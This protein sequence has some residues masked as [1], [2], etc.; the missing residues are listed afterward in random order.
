MAWSQVFPLGHMSG[1]RRAILNGLPRLLC[2]SKQMMLISIWNHEH[3]YVYQSGLGRFNS[4]SVTDTLVL[5]EP[6]LFQGGTFAG[7]CVIV[8]LMY[9]SYHELSVHGALF[10]NVMAKHCLSYNQQFTLILCS[11]SLSTR[12]VSNFL[13][14]TLT[15]VRRLH[16]P[17]HLADGQALHRRLL[18]LGAPGVRRE[19]RLSL[20][21]LTPCRPR[22]IIRRRASCFST[23]WFHNAIEFKNSNGAALRQVRHANGQLW[24][25]QD[26]DGW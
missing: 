17:V 5:T 15:F 16:E 13:L 12:G 4:F 20:W 1:R 11:S 23:L 18:R 9:I 19:H 10:V 6:Y 21:T 14:L 3:V 24:R 2:S 25:V 8:E 7:V 26:C 22:T